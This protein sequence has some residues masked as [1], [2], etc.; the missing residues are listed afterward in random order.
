MAYRSVRASK[1]KL[2]IIHL[3]GKVGAKVFQFFIEYMH[4][5]TEHV[6]QRKE[7][8]NL[9]QQILLEKANEDEL[10]SLFSS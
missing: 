2:K 4:R 10:S 3:Q 9:L 1:K 5:T 6:L 7:R 8:N